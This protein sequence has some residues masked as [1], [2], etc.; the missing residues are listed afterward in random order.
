MRYWTVVDQESIV[1]K[2]VTC[3]LSI[4]F[5]RW[6]L[7]GRP[8]D[9]ALFEKVRSMTARFHTGEPLIESRGG[10][11]MFV[12]AS[13]GS[14]RSEDVRLEA[15]S[16]GLQDDIL[17]NWDGRLDNGAEIGA[18]LNA[19][20]RGLVTDAD[21]VQAAFQ[22]WG[23]ACFQHLVGD[24]AVAI[25]D[26][27]QR[28]VVLARDFVGV[29]QLYFDR[30]TDHLNWCTVLDPLLHLRGRGSEICDEY[31]IGY[32][33]TLQPSHPTPFIGISAVAPGTM[34]VIEDRKVSLQVYWK[35]DP[36]R[37]T[38]YSSDA[39]YEELLRIL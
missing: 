18:Q 33:S 13:R 29:R 16:S 32:L 6:N 1:H 25:W 12:H 4:Q 15:R 7:D 27:V 39:D 17:L 2:R 14:R 3:F 21:F 38:R 35:F 26:G 36:S 8:I 34:V 20:S 23:L 11:A 10:L 37:R 28:R 22:Q 31:L 9:P 5:G 19:K 24:W 30:Q